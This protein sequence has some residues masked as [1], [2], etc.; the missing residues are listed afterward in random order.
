MVKPH[1]TTAAINVV[2]QSLGSLGSSTRT[3]M[4]SSSMCY[5]QSKEK[6]SIA[7]TNH[8]LGSGVALL[9]THFVISRRERQTL[10]RV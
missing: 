1:N 10:P 9:L 6:Q 8:R 2:T 7:W 5:E 4:T 3:D